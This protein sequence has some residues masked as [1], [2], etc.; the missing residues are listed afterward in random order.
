MWFNPFG[1]DYNS[2]IE[3]FFEK[4]FKNTTL[5]SNIKALIKYASFGNPR[6]FVTILR[7]YELK[8]VP[9]KVNLIKLLMREVNC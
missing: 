6:A 1:E 8:K 9:H 5:D 7:D 2:F 4:R 3:E